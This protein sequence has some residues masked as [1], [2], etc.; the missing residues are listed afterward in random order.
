MTEEH[1]EM[2]LKITH[3]RY[4]RWISSAHVMCFLVAKETSQLR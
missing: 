2:K 3:L 1:E 4:L